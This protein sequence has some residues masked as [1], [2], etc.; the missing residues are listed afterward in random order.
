MLLIIKHGEFMILTRQ[1]P[2]GGPALKGFPIEEDLD[3]GVLGYKIGYCS[4]GCDQPLLIRTVDVRQVV[5]KFG[6]SLD[7]YDSSLFKLKSKKPLRD[8]II[9]FLGGRVD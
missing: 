9:N 8:K 5:T 3:T 6:I 7:E 2:K 4:C 1:N